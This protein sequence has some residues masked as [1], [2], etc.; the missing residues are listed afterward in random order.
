M[1]D[2]AILKTSNVGPI[3]A[4]RTSLWNEIFRARWSYL[5]VA[6]F[7]IFFALFSLYPV[8]FSLYLS[9]TEWKGLG[10]INFIGLDNY[11]RLL[12]DT[13][14]WQSMLNG[15]LLFMMYVPLMTLL[16]LVLAVILNS[17]RVRGFRIFRTIIFIPYVT[18]MVA[19]GFSFRLLLNQSDGLI[20]QM[21]AVVGIAPVPWL[22]SVAGARVSLCLLII[23][24]WLGYN[25]VLM[26]AGLQTIPA[27]LTEAAQID[28]ANSGQAFM[29]ITIPLM[30]PVL[31][32][33]IVLSTMGSFG[34]FT[35]VSILTNGAG[36]MNATITPIA[37]I[38]NHPFF[39]FRLS[40]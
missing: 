10:P 4:R 5:F 2:S 33:S 31:T 3:K 8:L 1:S 37:Y 35:E 34:L 24:A 19:A 25:M 9:L 16:A 22:E 12:H 15:V 28:G 6:P 13:V 40:Y 26:L 21:L 29:Y 38:S 32:F 18:N 17:R 14:F 39:N 27:D 30:R 7:F 36:P 11:Q 23:W 20:N